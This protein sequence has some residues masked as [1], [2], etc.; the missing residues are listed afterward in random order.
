M[1]LLYKTVKVSIAPPCS[2]FYIQIPSGAED[3]VT[4]DYYI[5]FEAN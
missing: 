3:Y 1:V 2:L 5:H 4:N